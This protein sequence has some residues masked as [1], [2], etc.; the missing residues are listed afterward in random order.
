MVGNVKRNYKGP[1]TKCLYFFRISNFSSASSLMC[2]EVSKKHSLFIGCK[3]AA[4]SHPHPSIHYLNYLSLTRVTG[5]LEP[6]PVVT[7]RKANKPEKSPVQG[8]VDI[9]THSCTH[10]TISHLQFA[11]RACFWTV[12]GTQSTRWTPMQIWREHAI[13]TQKWPSAVPAGDLLAIR[14]HCHPQIRFGHSDKTWNIFH[15]FQMLMFNIKQ[16][17]KDTH[18]QWLSL[19]DSHVGEIST[20]IQLHI[21]RICIKL[22]WY[23]YHKLQVWFT[24]ADQRA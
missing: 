9:Q 22:L 24:I 15:T 17:K 7:G 20:A 6:M 4:K 13:D 21:S 16:T 5:L 23:L 2:S 19:L 10:S 11:Q 12:G 1:W 14:W 3:K 8:R 18:R